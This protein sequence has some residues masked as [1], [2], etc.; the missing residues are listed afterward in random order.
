MTQPARA[1]RLRL[2][3]IDDDPMLLKSLRSALEIDQHIVTTVDGGQAGIE[4]FRRAEHDGVPF[5]AVVT[6]LG[7]PY[8]DGRRVASAIKEL[9]P[10]TPV[11]MLTGWGQRRR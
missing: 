10:R 5:A 6:D 9:A 4:A 1:S 8:V 7:M 2:L 11:I 3:V